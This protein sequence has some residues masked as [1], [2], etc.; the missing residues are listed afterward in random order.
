MAILV[1]E[2]VEMNL[3]R[4]EI[5]TLRELAK[6]YMEAASLPVQQEK[7]KLWK[8]LNRGQM[9]RPM[10]VIEQLPW[11]ELNF[12]G[13]LTCTVQDSYWRG[14]E[15]FLRQSLYKW[16]NFPVDMVLDPF[17]SIPLTITDVS[18]G[19]KIEDECVSFDDR[20]NVVSH[21]YINQLA[22]MEDLEKIKDPDFVYEKEISE[23]HLEQARQIF[24]GIAE[25]KPM[26]Q[27]FHCGIWDRISMLMGVENIYIDL[28]ERPDFI[29]AI[30][31]R[32]TQ[33]ILHGL[34]QCNTLQLHN[35]NANSCH[36]SYIY[37]DELLP[38]S[39][40]GKD[41]ISKN[42]WAFGMAQLF[43]STSPAVTKEFEL[44]YVSQMAE[45]FGMFYYG[46]CER[47]DDRLEIIQRIPNLKKIS[48]SPWS[49]KEAFAEKLAPQLIMSNKPNPAYVAMNSLDENIIRRD[50]SE[51]CLEAK[52]HNAN[53]EFI[54]KDISTVCY[55]PERLAKWAKIAM[56]VAESFG[57]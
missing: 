56:E 7:I 48:C 21:H 9:E 22:D 32:F 46:C 2:V 33:G 50:L 54:L 52:R 24:Q 27:S 23:L 4:Q 29:H 44:P 20:N 10:V 36:C 39:G 51:T 12:D 43:S 47:L 15:N 40:M 16:R 55:Q 57:G 35:V 30:M 17:I 53:V 14:I 3:S 25:V 38:G 31:E 13:S 5:G 41:A 49:N 18:Q 6:Q 42:C 1:D 34:D 8:S 45:K 37:T 19:V 26:G 28:M 11:H